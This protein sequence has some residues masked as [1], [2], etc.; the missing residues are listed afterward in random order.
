MHDVK[1][2]LVSQL[3]ASGTDFYLQCLTS[4]NKKYPQIKD[5]R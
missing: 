3:S 2:Q 4:S 1:L 5:V